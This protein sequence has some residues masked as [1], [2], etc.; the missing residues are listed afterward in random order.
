MGTP[1]LPNANMLPKAAIHP[2]VSSL[3]FLGRAIVMMLGKWNWQLLQKQSD[4]P[5]A[6]QEFEGAKCI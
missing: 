6:E 4:D 3:I 2:I 5:L 1:K